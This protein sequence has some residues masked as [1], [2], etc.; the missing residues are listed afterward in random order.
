MAIELH[1]F[2]VVG[3]SSLLMHSPKNMGKD[4]SGDGLAAKKYPAPDVEAE[5]VAYR[6]DDGFL[7]LPSI[8]FRASLLRACMGRK[9]G[10]Y[11]ANSQ[12]AA[13]VFNADVQTRLAHPKT[14]KPIKDYKVKPDPV[15]IQKQRV[16]KY[17][18]EIPE[19]SAE[20]TFEIDT[21]FV[22]K[23]QVKELLNIAGR[24]AGVGDWRP[25][26]K[27]PHGRYQVA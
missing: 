7:F 17:R 4:K 6:D 19:W 25:A 15:V 14:G 24:I 9:I 12:V 20:V 23:Q 21:D 26:C 27:G 5:S 22:T 1:K 16:L 8:A 18:P 13:G 10:K 2:K 3:I 11:S